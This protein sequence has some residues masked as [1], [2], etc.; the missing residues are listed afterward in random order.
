MKYCI[1]VYMIELFNFFFDV[2]VVGR[3]FFCS[4]LK[5]FIVFIKV[6]VKC[7]CCDYLNN[8]IFILFIWYVYWGF[9]GLVKF[10]FMSF[11]FGFGIFLMVVIRCFFECLEGMFVL[12]ILW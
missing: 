11:W 10:S 8:G 1:L 4:V 3:V 12:F 7:C 9:I 6:F 2:V 5:F